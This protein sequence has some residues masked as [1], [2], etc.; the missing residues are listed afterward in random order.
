MQTKQTVHGPTPAGGD[1]SVAFFT[2]AKGQPAD[3]KKATTV[4]IVEYLN[5]KQ[6]AR[7]HME[8]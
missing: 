6:I 7:T 3:K 8:R 1:K 5:G 4:E 2:D